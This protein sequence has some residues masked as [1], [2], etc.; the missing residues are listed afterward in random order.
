MENIYFTNPEYFWLLILLAPMLL[1][2]IL[3]KK[4]SQATI[5]VSDISSFKSSKNSFKKYLRHILF[6]LRAATIAMLV[7]VIAGPQSQLSKPPEKEVHGIDIVIALDISSSMLARDFNP[8]RLDASKDIAVKFISGRENDQ[9]GLVVFAGES[10]TQC[11]LTSDRKQLINLF[12][13]IEQ[14]MLEDGT[15]IGMGLANAVERLTES[16]A[17]SKVVILLT[18]GENNSGQIDPLTAADLA[19]KYNIRVYTVGVGKNGKAPYPVMD[20]F[21]RISYR[22]MDV[23]IDEKTLKEIAAKTDGKYFRATDNEKLKAIY[24]KI[25]KLEKSR[26]SVR[27]FDLKKDEYFIFALLAGIF[28]LTELLLR[29]TVFRS[30]P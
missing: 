27:E 25:D 16:K 22:N 6:I 13:S 26:I 5:T 4:N 18:D 11:P 1:W 28:L 29:V 23:K 8:N 14:G 9:V 2:Y 20:A 24:E 12:G 15:A 10:F 30:I 19:A 7:A 17:K 21:G 3:K